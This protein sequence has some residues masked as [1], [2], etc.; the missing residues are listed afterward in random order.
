MSVAPGSNSSFL[1]L[2]ITAYRKEG[3]SE[4]DYRE[5]MTNSHAPLVKPLMEKHG[6]LRYSLVRKPRRSKSMIH[7]SSLKQ[8]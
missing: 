3:L 8:S 6:L 2:T 1:C 5:Y 4:E 7:Y